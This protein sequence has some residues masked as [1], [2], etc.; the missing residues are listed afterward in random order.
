MNVKEWQSRLQR[1][2][3]L[4]EVI[5]WQIE[6]RSSEPMRRTCE[7]QL[8]R[9]NQDIDCCITSIEQVKKREK[10]IKKSYVPEVKLGKIS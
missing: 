9:V 6:N 2:V 7:K 5:E 1:K 3:E 10:F 8:E 4:K